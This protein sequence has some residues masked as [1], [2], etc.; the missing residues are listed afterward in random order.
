M[1]E[2]NEFAESAAKEISALPIEG[3]RQFVKA[4]ASYLGAQDEVIMDL[5][6]A[7]LSKTQKYHHITRWMGKRFE[8]DMTLSP[9]RV[10][11]ECVYYLRVNSK[12][13][14]LLIKTGQ[15]VKDRIRHR[16][17]YATHK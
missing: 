16:R 10:A 6:E 15:K 1:L 8:K 17:S 4:L 14:P 3:Q 9:K 5:I 2:L 7:M 12:M 11:E 13:M